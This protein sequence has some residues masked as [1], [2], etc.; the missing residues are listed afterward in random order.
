MALSAHDFL[1]HDSSGNVAIAMGDTV[2]GDGSVG[3]APSCL[4][5]KA[6]GTVW[7]NNATDNASSNFDQLTTP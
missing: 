3:Y 1:L 2:P 5:L 7:W 4:F 6:D